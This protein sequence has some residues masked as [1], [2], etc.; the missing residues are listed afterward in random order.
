MVYTGCYQ[1][2]PS[3]QLKQNANQ[4]TVLIQEKAFTAEFIPVKSFN[5]VHFNFPGKFLLSYNTAMVWY[6]VDAISAI[7]PPPPP[8]INS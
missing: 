4:K 5:F 8:P 3:E 7:P 2:N 1:C 6:T